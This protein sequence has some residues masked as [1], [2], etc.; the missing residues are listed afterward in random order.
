MSKLRLHLLQTPV[1]VWFTASL[2]CCCG[3]QPH[4]EAAA[5]PLGADPEAGQRPRHQSD[6]CVL[7]IKDPQTCRSGQ[8]GSQGGRCQWEHWDASHVST[9]EPRRPEEPP[10][11]TE[12]HSESW[13]CTPPPHDSWAGETHLP[14]RASQPERVWISVVR[15][16][17]WTVWFKLRTET[18]S[19]LF[20]FPGTLKTGRL[21]KLEF[22]P[23][24]NCCMKFH[25][26]KLFMVGSSK[27]YRF[28][29]SKLF[30]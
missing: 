21:C 12:D 5:G 2:Q 19:N 9:P 25:G 29:V 15:L 14:L 1:F 13:G 26:I 28:N 27:V 6:W 4:E 7:T 17:T 20:L 11:P 22:A 30:S 24:C 8:A 10:P 16:H 3:H 23:S 18:W